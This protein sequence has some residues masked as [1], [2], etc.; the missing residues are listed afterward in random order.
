MLVSFN[1]LRLATTESTLVN[2]VGQVLLH[3][4]VDLFDSGIEARFRGAR[5][6]E[7]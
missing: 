7:V 4:L 2:E 6:V 3:E 5:D 1:I